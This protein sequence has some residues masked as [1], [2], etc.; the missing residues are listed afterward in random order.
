MLANL[1]YPRALSILSLRFSNELPK[2]LHCN[3]QFSFSVFLLICGLFVDGTYAMIT[4]AI[5]SDLVS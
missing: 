2:K 5:S 4:T 1:F 3:R